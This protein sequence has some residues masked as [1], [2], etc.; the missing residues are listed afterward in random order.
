MLKKI[1]TNKEFQVWKGPKG[2]ILEA[3]PVYTKT[4][5]DAI[6]EKHEIC[7]SDVLGAKMYQLDQIGYMVIGE[8]MEQFQFINKEFFEKQC[9]KLD[10]L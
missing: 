1:N 4:Y 7:V 2:D 9:E 6:T 3:L 10:N 8:G 5:V